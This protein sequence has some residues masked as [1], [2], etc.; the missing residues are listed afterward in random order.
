ME[1]EFGWPMGPAYLLD[2]VGVDTAEHCTEVMSDGFPTRMQ[3]IANDPVSLLYKNNR[4]GQK[5]GL[6]FY[7][8]SKD[9]RGRPVKIASDTAYEIFSPTGDVVL[10][11]AEYEGK[12]LAGVM[13]FKCG[14]Q[15]SYLYGASNSEERNRMPTY[16]IQWA[17]I[18]WSKAQGCTSYDMWGLPDA[19]A[20]ELEAQFKE[21]SDGLWGVY[22]FKRGFNGKVARTVGCADKVYNDL[23]YRLYKRRRAA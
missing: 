12:P 10:L 6:G 17:A 16:A 13:I 5:N 22:R 11:L 19:D 9:K 14:K 2:V 7:D 20:E 15:A 21:K 1:K 4:F 18:Q 23:V 8:H 3:K